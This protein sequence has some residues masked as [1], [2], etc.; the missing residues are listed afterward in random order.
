MEWKFSEDKNEWAS[1]W[2]AHLAESARKREPGTLCYKFLHDTMEER[3]AAIFEAYTQKS[4]WT[5]AHDKGPAVSRWRSE[6]FRKAT[7]V[8]PIK[9][10]AL[11]HY[12][13]ANMGFMASDRADAFSGRGY[14]L[15]TELAFASRA[16]R[17]QWKARYFESRAARVRKDEPRCLAFA[18][19]DHETKGSEG[20]SLERYETKQD[21]SKN[22]DSVL[23]F[24]DSLGNEGIRV[25]IYA[26]DEG[27]EGFF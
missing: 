4:A 26:Y 10:K 13:D 11:G 15:L 6:A 5:D 17:E 23:H 16:A 22:Q 24:G 7:K 21:A 25:Q 19:F 20:L 27:K 2:H 8:P 9:D 1:L 3:S 18:F 14:V 12:S